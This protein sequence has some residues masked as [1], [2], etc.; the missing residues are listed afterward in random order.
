MLDIMFLFL[1]DIIDNKVLTDTEF[2]EKHIEISDCKCREQRYQPSL[3]CIP[4][5]DDD[6][7]ESDKS[8]TPMYRNKYK[9][10]EYARRHHSSSSRLRKYSSE[11]DTTK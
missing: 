5:A 4:E 10:S 11:K 2:I 3:Q 1:G 7:Y 6:G 9:R 8:D